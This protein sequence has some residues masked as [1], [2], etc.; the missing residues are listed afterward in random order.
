MSTEKSWKKKRSQQLDSPS[1]FLSGNNA[2]VMF[3]TKDWI[4]SY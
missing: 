1:L 3:I 4:L 2:N